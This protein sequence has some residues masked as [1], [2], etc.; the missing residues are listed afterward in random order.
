MPTIINKATHEVL[1]VRDETPYSESEWLILSAAWLEQHGMPTFDRSLWR[2][3]NGV[4]IE[5][6]PPEVV[7]SMADRHAREQR[8]GYGVELFNGWRMRWTDN[9]QLK[10]GL[11][12][13]TADMIAM[14]GD[15]SPK[16]PFYE[17]D[18]TEH[19]STYAEAY[20]I[21]GDY[22]IKVMAQQARQKQERENG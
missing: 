20:Q 9:D 8:E 4:V 11:A 16:V 21:L 18:G 13:A 6:E 19:A 12:K 17:V 14:T 5:G 22:M 2:Y 1:D 7:E 3:S 15:T 10:M